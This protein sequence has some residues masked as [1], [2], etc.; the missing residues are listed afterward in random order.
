L[1]YFVTVTCF[2]QPTSAV[3]CTVISPAD[4]GWGTLRWCL[5]DAVSGDT[6]TFAIWHLLG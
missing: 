2:V 5:A 6:I 1:A 4:N 3:P